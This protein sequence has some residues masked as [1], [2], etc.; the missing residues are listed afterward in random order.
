[1]PATDRK[2]TKMQLENQLACLKAEN[3]RLKRLIDTLSCPSPVKGW[4]AFPIP[5]KQKTLIM[6]WLH[7]WISWEMHEC[8]PATGVTQYCVV[9]TQCCS[10]SD[11]FPVVLA[12]DVRLMVS[13]MYDS[14]D[15]SQ[16]CDAWFAAKHN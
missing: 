12:S 13:F 5:A 16:A 2:A 6:D 15:G 3:A 10:G 9:D 11:V 8:D 14:E 1:M 7:N 4:L